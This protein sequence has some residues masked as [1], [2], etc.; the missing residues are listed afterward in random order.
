MENE[1][2]LLRLRLIIHG[3]KDFYDQDGAEIKSILEE[4]GHAE[5]NKMMDSLETALIWLRRLV[6]DAIDS[7]A[8]ENA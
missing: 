1:L 8:K 2:A 7:E 4:L 5:Y 3:A 6:E